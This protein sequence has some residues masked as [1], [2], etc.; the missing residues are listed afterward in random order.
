MAL[1]SAVTLGN[2]KLKNCWHCLTVSM[3][4][5]LNN[6]MKNR[7]ITKYCLCSD[8]LM[9]PGWRGNAVVAQHQK[10]WGRGGQK[11]WAGPISLKSSGDITSRKFLVKILHFGIFCVRKC[12][13]ASYDKI[14]VTTCQRLLGGDQRYCFDP[15]L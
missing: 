3:L 8:V 1:F 7:S 6:F 9:H 2:S 5:V 13:S 14:S 4:F 11:A 12:A 15:Y 10:Y